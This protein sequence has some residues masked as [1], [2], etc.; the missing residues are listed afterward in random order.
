MLT[1]LTLLSSSLQA[2]P[3]INS[4]FLKFLELDQT[5]EEANND[6]VLGEGASEEARNNFVR[7]VEIRNL[8]QRYSR[9][10]RLTT[11]NRCTEE[12]GYNAK[13]YQRCVQ[14]RSED[15]CRSTCQCAYGNDGSGVQKLQLLDGNPLRKLLQRSR[16]T[17]KSVPE[18]CKTSKKEKCRDV[19]LYGQ[20][21]RL[22]RVVPVKICRKINLL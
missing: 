21:K 16:R 22:C 3:P 15:I 9:N 6:F 12:D 18:I 4:K 14:Y 17:W 20:K 7:G 19:W 8:L 5:N 10:D 2:A 1:V 11:R 13:C